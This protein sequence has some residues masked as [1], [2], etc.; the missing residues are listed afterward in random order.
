MKKVCGLDVR[1]D[2]IFLCNLQWRRYSEV[3][4]YEKTPHLLNIKYAF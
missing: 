4:E 3:K 1:K 2:N